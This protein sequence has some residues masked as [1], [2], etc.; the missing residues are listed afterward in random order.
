MT[1]AVSPNGTGGTNIFAGGLECGVVLSTNNGTSWTPVNA[2]T[3]TP[4]AVYA[5][6]VSGT[7]LFAGTSYNGVLLSTN[8]GTSWTAVNSGLPI[9]DLGGGNW[10]ITA[11]HS[12]AVSPNGAGGTN[13]FAGTGTGKDGIFLS[14]NNGTS[15]TAVNTGL[16]T[17]AAVTEWVFSSF[18]FSPNG[19]GGTNI[20]AGTQDG[21]FLSTNHGTSWT[22]SGT[23]LIIY[24]V[25]ITAL[26]VS[27]NGAGG[28][29]IFAGT[30]GSGVY[31]S[32]DNGSTNWTQVNSGLTGFNTL[33]NALAVSGKNLFAGVS[34]I[35]GTHSGGVFLSTNNGTSWTGVSSGLATDDVWSL[36]VSGNNLFAGTDNGIYVRPLNEMI[37]SVRQVTNETP[38]QFM[39]AQNYPNPFNPSTTMQFS[40]P[41]ATYVTLNIYNSLG[42][43]VALL[44]SENLN[45][46]TYT[47]E[48]NASGF[49]SGIY[50]YRLQAGT[51]TETKKLIL[52]R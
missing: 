47:K 7:N 13:I 3:G 49:A 15:W 11:V 36:G 37:T 31:L 29:N 18:A 9:H 12:L 32:T 1:F 10:E 39:L 2:G 6:A 4:P 5:L 24:P 19:A 43:E 28:T 17:D 8:N 45:A 33:V 44:V 30:N 22:G 27:P 48:W 50:Y 46:G 25:D 34:G 16:M 51:F 41:K 23:G 20:F 40:L 21:I 52:L 38:R 35:I 42:Q 14:T 26:V